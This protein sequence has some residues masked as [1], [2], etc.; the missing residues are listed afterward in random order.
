MRENGRALLHILG[1]SLTVP[2]DTAEVDGLAIAIEK[3]SK[4]SCG[5]VA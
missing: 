4:E 2:R 1:H 3:M 5:D